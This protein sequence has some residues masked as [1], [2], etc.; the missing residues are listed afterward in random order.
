MVLFTVCGKNSSSEGMK[1]QKKVVS[2]YD[3]IFKSAV[4]VDIQILHHVIT[5]SYYFRDG[6][7]KLVRQDVDLL[8]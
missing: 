5:I 6:Y 1:N 4:L 3:T 7:D 8:L 2:P